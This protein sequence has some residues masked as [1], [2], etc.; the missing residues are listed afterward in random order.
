[1]NSKK[2]LI[3]TKII[4]M[5]VSPNK[6]KTPKDK[7]RQINKKEALKNKERQSRKRKYKTLINNYRKGIEEYL[8]QSNVNLSNLKKMFKKEQKNLDKAVQKGIIH[9]NRAAKKKSKYS[10]KINDLEKQVKLD[11]ST[12]AE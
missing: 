10:K 11:N 9:K 2:L 12:S 4:Y 7:K 8:G 6:E 3:N 5:A 1:M